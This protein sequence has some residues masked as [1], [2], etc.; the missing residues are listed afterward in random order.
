MLHRIPKNESKN[1]NLNKS[2]KCMYSLQSDQDI[3]LC[4]RKRLTSQIV[5]E[6]QRC[7]TSAL[8]LQ[9]LEH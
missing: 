3:V 9:I 5:T 2:S 4:H 1:S 6:Q 7:A 8:C